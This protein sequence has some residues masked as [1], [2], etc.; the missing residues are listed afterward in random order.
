VWAVASRARRACTINCRRQ[1]TS[2]AAQRGVVLATTLGCF[3]RT[4]SPSP[5]WRI[6]LNRSPVRWIR[7]N[8]ITRG[9]ER[10]HRRNARE[11]IIDRGKEL[12]PSTPTPLWVLA[13]LRTLR[14]E[15][16]SQIWQ[17]LSSSRD[18]RRPSTAI[19]TPSREPKFNNVSM[20]SDSP[21][22]AA[23]PGAATSRLRS[24]LGRLTPS[25][26]HGPKRAGRIHFRGQQTVSFRAIRFRWPE[27][28]P[29]G[30][31][32]RVGND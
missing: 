8:H 6:L 26:T 28:P 27:Q 22:F 10:D 21:I 7:G 9:G 13:R 25:A 5:E 31:Q 3:Q 29:R 11:A 15:P 1:P 32:R 12:S 2:T 17:V 30:P 4:T 20:S 14:R 19:E 24:A 23:Q 16:C 18:P